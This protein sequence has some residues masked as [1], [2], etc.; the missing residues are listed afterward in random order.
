MQICKKK[1]E[2]AQSLAGFKQDSAGFEKGFAG[3]EQGSANYLGL[4]RMCMA[5][6]PSCLTSKG[7]KMLPI[8]ESFLYV[9]NNLLSKMDNLD[10][11]CKNKYCRD[12]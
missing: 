4:N 5:P 3:L 11:F 6:T 2:Q 10:F 8:K 7:L 12:P 9:K 1:F